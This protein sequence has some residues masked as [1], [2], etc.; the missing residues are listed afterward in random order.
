MSRARKVAGV[1][2]GML[3]LGYIFV[4]SDAVQLKKQQI[5]YTLKERSELAKHY[6]NG[7]GVTKD[8]NKAKEWYIKAA[9]QGDK[10]AQQALDKLNQ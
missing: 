2:V 3:A 8:V 6:K 7:I 1:G 4:Q 9:A 5:E 10:D